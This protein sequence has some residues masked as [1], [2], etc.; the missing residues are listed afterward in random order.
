M[1]NEESLVPVAIATWKSNLG[2]ANKLFGGLD[3]S[4]LE[5]QVAPDRNRLVYLW[6]HLAS[7]HDRMLQLLGIAERVHPEFDAIFLSSPDGASTLPPVDVMR[8]WWAQVNRR[9]EAGLRELT[10][11][12]WV[13]RHTAVSEEDFTKEPLRNRF[14]IL[15][16][17]TNHLAYHVGQ[18]TLATK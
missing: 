9:L 6:G 13:A 8:E 3:E 18:A 10:L 16:T 1:L 17:R 5:K 12:D 11:N 4:A 2:R 15:I 7:T 14:S